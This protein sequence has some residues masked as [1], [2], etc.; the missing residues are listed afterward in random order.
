M[1]VAVILLRK[2]VIH[3]PLPGRIPCLGCPRLSSGP[4]LYLPLLTEGQRVVSTGSFPLPI[5]IY[6][7]PQENLERLPSGLAYPSRLSFHRYSWVF[8][9][10][11]GRRSQ[12]A[13]DL[14]LIAGFTFPRI[15]KHKCFC[16]NQNTKL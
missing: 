5:A 7:Q 15:Q 3:P 2:E 10:P 9:R 1:N 4:G 12:L 13:Y 11:R 14:I 8:H 16:K 6:L